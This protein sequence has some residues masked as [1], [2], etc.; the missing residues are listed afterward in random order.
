MD[1]K[2]F[3]CIALTSPIWLCTGFVIVCV[4]IPLLIT[5]YVIAIVE[6]GFTGD[7]DSPL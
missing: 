7:W 4:A 1:I 5:E 2:R 3:L 6:Y